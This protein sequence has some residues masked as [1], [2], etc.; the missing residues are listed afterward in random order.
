MARYDIGRKI[1]LCLG[2]AWRAAPARIDIDRETLAHIAPM[3]IGSGAANLVWRRLA[4]TP[5]GATPIG[6]ILRDAARRQAFVAAARLALLRR[7][8]RAFAGDGLSP[9]LFKGWALSSAYADPFLRP[10]GDLDFFAPPAQ[11]LR[12]CD[13]LATL[14]SCV[15]ASDKERTYHIPGPGPGG[16]VHVDMHSTLPSYYWIDPEAF[17]ATAAASTLSDGTPIRTPAPELHLRLVVMH[18]LKHGGWRPL[19]LCDIAALTETVGSGFDWQACLTTD[20]CAREW[21]GAALGVA[22][23][24]VGC[25]I[26]EPGLAAK[27][28]SWL[29]NS[30]L[31]EWRAPYARRFRAPEFEASAKFLLKKA[32]SYWP[33]PIEGALKR[34]AAPTAARPWRSQAAYFVDN[35]SRGLG[36]SMRKIF[37]QA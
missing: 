10:L 6:N 36:K 18:F 21:M 1:A 32:A 8:A 5:V 29:T 4:K 13:V 12:A 3:L 11:Y 24:L 27:P 31:N 23:E 22:H 26:P 19:W 17:A 25:R 20:S 34:G 14:G 33:N 15:A 37:L 2:G 16:G 7:V 35:A 28:P 30:I 9:V